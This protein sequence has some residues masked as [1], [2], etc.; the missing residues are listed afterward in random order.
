[1]L[2]NTGYKFTQVFP[3]VDQ[4]SIL[5][6]PEYFAMNLDQ[7]TKD[8]Q[9]PAFL[10]ELLNKFPWTGRNNVI[11]VKPQDFRISKPATLG[12]GIH[13][14]LNVRLNDGK[15][16]MADSVDDFKLFVTSFGEVV[17]TEFVKDS[18][19]LPALK[20]DL[21]NLMEVFGALPAKVEW[22]SSAPN[23]LCEYTSRDFHRMGTNYKLGKARLLVVAFECNKNLADGKVLPNILTRGNLKLE[24]YTK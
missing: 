20:D 5:N 2:Y 21:S 4:E 14:D 18:L 16:R 3:E 13:L 7:V 23:Q 9:C 10:K 1:L 11:Q 6:C 17:E 19:E 15:T 24:D 12:E 22:N 8:L